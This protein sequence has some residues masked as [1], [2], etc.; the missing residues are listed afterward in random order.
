MD[1]ISHSGPKLNMSSTKHVGGLG[2][3]WYAY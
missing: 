3:N 1:E 2:M